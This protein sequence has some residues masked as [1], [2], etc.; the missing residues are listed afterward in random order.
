MDWKYSA[1][2]HVIGLLDNL[3]EGFYCDKFRKL[4]HWCIFI[5]NN[6]HF[7]WQLPIQLIPNS[8]IN[9]KVFNVQILIRN[10]FN[11]NLS[12]LNQL[13]LFHW[14]LSIN[15][16]NFLWDSLS[17]S[18]LLRLELNSL[19]LFENRNEFEFDFTGFE[20]TRNGYISNV[21]KLMKPVEDI[22][23]CISGKKELD[24]YLIGLCG[25]SIIKVELSAC[26]ESGLL[27]GDLKIFEFPSWFSTPLKYKLIRRYFQKGTQ[28]SF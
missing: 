20:S 16:T 19:E 27:E 28:L 14:F 2:T 17:D 5:N 23:G 21:L 26:N 12:F 15:L 18:K 9:R 22:I 1:N 13:L 4:F 24:T 10:Q 8:K 11:G 7:L 3:I 6:L 25:Y